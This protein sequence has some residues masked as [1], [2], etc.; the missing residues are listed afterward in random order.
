MKFFKK[1]K[2]MAAVMLAAIVLIL[3]ITPVYAGYYSDSDADHKDISFDEMQASVN[4]NYDT[5]DRSIDALVEAVRL[6]SSNSKVESCYREMLKQVDIMVT[7]S[8]LTQLEFYKDVYNDEQSDRLEKISAE[9]IELGDKATL[10]ISMMVKSDYRFLVE[11]D[12]GEGA[13]D[14]EDYVG[15]TQ[16]EK[17]MAAREEALE[18]EYESYSQMDSIPENERYQHLAEVYIELVK[19]RKEIAQYSGYKTYRDYAYEAIYGRDY[20]AGDADVYH[21]QVKRSVVDLYSSVVS[22]ILED[23][24]TYQAFWDKECKGLD[25]VLAVMDKHLA[26]IHPELKKSFEYFKKNHVYY[27]D[28]NEKMFDAGY[29][30]NLYA[31]NT[32]F[33][34][35]ALYGN[36]YDYTDVFHEFGHFN[37]MFHEKCYAMYHESSV[38]VAEIH[39]QGMELFFLEW[40][41]ECYGQELAE[42]A[43]L[44]ALYRML[45]NVISGSLQDEFQAVVFELPDEDLTVDNLTRIYATLLKSYGRSDEAAYS[46]VDISHTFTSPFYYLSY[47]TSAMGALQIYEMSKSDR[48]KA[49]DCYMR[50]TALP[51]SVGYCEAV[52][53]VGLKN[54]MDNGVVREVCRS[55]AKSYNFYGF[56]DLSED[57]AGIMRGLM[58]MAKAVAYGGS[59]LIV[60]AVLVL[61][62]SRKSAHRR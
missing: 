62:F 45:D 20:T 16:E 17:D 6:G 53:S 43:R 9:M 55:L 34:Y 25:E 33:I 42:M 58:A 1:S 49:V 48:D 56:E 52:D 51:G 31:F 37:Q 18:T 27:I 22:R 40:A 35:N 13:I 21:S 3:N 50:L 38:D 4:Y 61:I 12:I 15:M 60:A 2:A 30:T 19:V 44:F 29:T 5:V 26:D 11:G 46:W 47:S 57:V 28:G 7:A 10:A 23:V 24:D 59:S 32:P 41:E 39:S 54:I 8:G 36:F 14:F